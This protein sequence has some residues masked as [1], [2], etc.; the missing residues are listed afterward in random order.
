MAASDEMEVEI[1]WRSVNV[2]FRQEEEI[3]VYP[4]VVGKSRHL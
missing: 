2:C 1:L 3:A 4:N